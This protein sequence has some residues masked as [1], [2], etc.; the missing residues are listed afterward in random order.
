[1]RVSDVGNSVL[2]F[3]LF[4]Q[5][6]ANKRRSDRMAASEALAYIVHVCGAKTPQNVQESL[7]RV[8]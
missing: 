2:P 3:R 6:S 5:V 4:Y 8:L 7:L 1:M